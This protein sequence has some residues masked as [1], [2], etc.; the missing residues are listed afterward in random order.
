MTLDLGF[1]KPYIESADLSINPDSTYNNGT[2]IYLKNLGKDLNISDPQLHSGQCLDFDGV[3]DYIPIDPFIKVRTVAFTMKVPGG[4]YNLITFKDSDYKGIITLEG[5]IGY[6]S[7]LSSASIYTNGVKT[8]TLSSGYNRIVL[9]FTDE[10]STDGTYSTIGHKASSNFN[11]FNGQMGNVQFW[12]VQWDLDDVLWDYENCYTGRTVDERN[13][14]SVTIDNLTLHYKMIEGSGN[15]IY[16]YVHPTGEYRTNTL[17]N[18]PTDDTQWSNTEQLTDPLVIQTCLNNFAITNSVCNNNSLYGNWDISNC[19]KTYLTPGSSYSYVRIEDNTTDLSSFYG[20]DDPFCVTVSE[21]TKYTLLFYAKN[22]GGTNAAYGIYDMTNGAY[23][24]EEQSYFSELNSSTLTPIY[25]TFTT[26]AG[27]TK[28]SPMLI[29]SVG[30]IDIIFGPFFN[31]YKGSVKDVAIPFPP[32]NIEV[33]DAI[34]PVLETEWNTAGL[35][36]DNYSRYCLNKK[37]YAT[38]NNL[39][40]TSALIYELIFKSSDLNN[41]YGNRIFLIGNNMVFF[42]SGTSFNFGIQESSDLFYNISI[43]V[44]DTESFSISDSI[45]VICIYSKDSELFEL[46]INGNLE[47]S[48]T[49]PEWLGLYDSTSDIKS[50]FGDNGV[51]Q[52]YGQ[53]FNIKVWYDDNAQDVINSGLS[54][55]VTERYNEA[56]LKYN[57]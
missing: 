31:V 57:L 43:G 32:N 7:S 27:C 56:K 15:T 35:L 14:T 30:P 5:F 55:W 24:V 20:W 3:D 21:N 51:F 39:Y 10:F 13:G 19:T 16:N 41:W 53:I 52:Y 46:Y 9:I 34:I 4:W 26:P 6:S 12:D 50:L 42:H 18:F 11:Y 40:P 36:N 1:K 33:T 45:H 17:T 47:G 37:A 2:G 29:N 48:S 25:C 44:G 22:N 38:F 54:D 8:S 28:I 49:D 23:I